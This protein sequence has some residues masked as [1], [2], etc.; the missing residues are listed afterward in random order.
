M[1]PR[2]E[3]K[4]DN[5]IDNFDK[6]FEYIKEAYTLTTENIEDE[7]EIRKTANE[8]IHK[9]SKIDNIT[10]EFAAIG[11]CALMQSGAYLKSVP[12]RKIN[13]N[14]HEFTKKTLIT[15][16]DLINNKYTLRS[17]A[18]NL[19]KTIAK[20]AYEYNIVGHLY[21]RYKIENPNTIAN[22]DTEINKK[23]AIY[24]TDFQIENPDTPIAIREYLANR[25]KNRA[26]KNVNLK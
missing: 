24:C 19:R 13:I 1:I 9:Y 14:N 4:S 3:Y 8:L 21:A 6:N 17:I 16:S 12:N 26:L 2:K 10:F 18:R 23:I 25:E 5:N 15:A 22:N 20:V 11:I 7:T